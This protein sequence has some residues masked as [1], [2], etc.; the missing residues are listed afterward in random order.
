MGRPQFFSPEEKAR[1]LGISRDNAEAE[2]EAQANTPPFGS[3]GVPASY[4]DLQNYWH[5]LH[6]QRSIQQTLASNRRHASGY[7][8]AGL[9][10]LPLGLDAASDPQVEPLGFAADEPLASQSPLWREFLEFENASF[11]A[12][13]SPAGPDG[14]SPLNLHRVIPPLEPPPTR[15]NSLASQS[16]FWNYAAFG[17]PRL[18]REALDRTQAH[19]AASYSQRPP[20]RREPMEL[21]SMSSTSR[22]TND[23]PL[24]PSP[25]SRSSSVSPDISALGTIVRHISDIRSHR[26]PRYYELCERYG[27]LL[28]RWCI[29]AHYRASY[30]LQGPAANV[31]RWSTI[32]SRF[33]DPVGRWHSRNTTETANAVRGITNFLQQYSDNHGPRYQCLQDIPLLKDFAEILLQ[34]GMEEERML[35]APLVLLHTGK[36]LDRIRIL[37]SPDSGV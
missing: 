32:E 5:N 23:I 10:G 24:P 26:L 1:N 3:Q 4:L 37:L 19:L 2:A 14:T 13:P 11:V 30:F 29:R 7:A 17:E 20:R 21:P 6:I 27:H 8:G 22:T 16:P 25:S 31:E 15:L 34:E 28:W 35:W 12:D 18:P 36:D 9:G 33:W